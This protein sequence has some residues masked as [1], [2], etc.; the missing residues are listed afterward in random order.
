[1][2]PVR[3]GPGPSGLSQFHLDP[4]VTYHGRSNGDPFLEDT[5]YDGDISM[6]SPLPPKRRHILRTSARR[7][8]CAP[9]TPPVSLSP[10]VFDKNVDTSLSFIKSPRRHRWGFGQVSPRMSTPVNE[11]QINCQPTSGPEGFTVE[12]PDE[13]STVPLPP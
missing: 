2:T 4:L 12:D 13:S 5:N 11:A 10:V 7:M 8:A 9:T 1:V 3:V 6:S